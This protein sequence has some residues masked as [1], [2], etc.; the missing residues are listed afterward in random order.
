V[1]S[2]FCI[3][4]FSTVVVAVIFVSFEF[5]PSIAGTCQSEWHSFFS[6]LAY[7]Y[8]YMTDKMAVIPTMDH[9]YLEVQC[10]GCIFL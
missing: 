4:I 2:N 1:T 5:G 6:T 9:D 10:I 7:A 3:V 8:P